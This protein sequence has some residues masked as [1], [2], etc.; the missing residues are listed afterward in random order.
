MTSSLDSARNLRALIPGVSL[1]PIPFKAKAPTLRGWPDLRLGDDDLSRHFNGKPQNLGVLLGEPSGGLV[2]VDLDVAEAIPLAPLFL[3]ATVTFG[4]PSKRRSHY[5]YRATGATTEKFTDPVDGA[6]LLELRST[7]C[8]TVFP[9]SVHPSGEAIDFDGDGE[10]PT[11]AEGDF[12]RILELAAATLLVRHGVDTTT[13]CDAVDAGSLDG[14][15]VPAAVADKAREWLGI[16]RKPAAPAP[17]RHASGDRDLLLRRARAYVA[18]MPAAI[19]GQGGHMATLDVALA[20]VRGF[21]LV[22][23]DVYRILAE[24]NQRCEPPWNEKELRHKLADAAKSTR[25]PSGYLLD[26][27]DR[28]LRSPVRASAPRGATAPQAPAQPSGGDGNGVEPKPEIVISVDEAAVADQTLEHLASASNL[29]RR[30]GSLVHVV[31]DEAGSKAKV[32][33]AP[34]A[35]R[36]VQMPPARLREIIAS[37]VRCVRVDSDGAR[38]AVHPPAWLVAL[39]EARGEWPML[40]P[41][42]SV[43]EAPTLRPDGSI[44]DVPG[45]DEATGILYRPTARFPRIEPKPSRDRCRAAVG[46]LAELVAD[47]PFEKPAH[48]SAWLAALLSVVGRFAFNGPAPLFLIDANVRGAGK[49]LAADVIALVATGRSAARM[50]PGD[51]DDELRKKITSLVVGGDRLILIDNIIGALGGA[52]LDAAL[53][54]DEW[55]DRILGT[56]GMV[57]LPLTAVWLATG[58]N[59]MLKGD[60]SRRA[61]HIRI[62]SPDELPEERSGFRFPDLRAYVRQQRAR[63][64]VEALT[65]LRGYFAAG[66]PVMNLPPW[67]SFEAW[68]AV[69]RNALVWVGEPDPG[70]TREELRRESDT[71]VMA[72]RTLITG[73]AEFVEA[74]GAPCTVRTALVELGRFPESYVALRTALADLTASPPDKLPTAHRVG[75]VLRKFRDR[76]V[77]GRALTSPGEDRN[78]V[79]LWTVK[80]A[81]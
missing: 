56:N 29:Y 21:A 80:E 63:L 65:I 38:V 34:G 12:L 70:A 7:G 27:P 40:P 64:V 28:S 6:M 37:E 59:V 78:G 57:R 8:Q 13:V 18:R 35:P 24:Y 31:D 49:S 62:A 33:R 1:I 16:A 15:D 26:D 76:V 43:I 72:L 23:S 11:L 81:G 32:D 42:L 75:F 53:T 36:I 30:G 9:G 17:T 48:R 67:G 52:S 25:V 55:T 20:L 61:A 54:G 44:L 5:L 4:R 74:Q 79:A 73:W 45:Y 39:T 68:S 58:N 3:P 77:G 41:L 71:E 46:A 19:S 69:V 66:R 60:T 50:A 22:D 2:D 10:I 51:D 14:L 47:F